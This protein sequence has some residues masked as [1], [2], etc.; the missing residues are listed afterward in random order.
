MAAPFLVKRRAGWYLRIRVPAALGIVLGSHLTRSL[1]TRDYDLARRR[2]VRAAARLQACW[3]EAWRDMD[4]RWRRAGALLTAEDLIR[5]D[6]AR[7]HAQLAAFSASFRARIDAELRA[8]AD[9]AAFAL[10]APADRQREREAGRQ[11]GRLEGMR[12]ALAALG[13]Q[14]RAGPAADVNRG[15]A[16]RKGSNRSGPA[17]PEI[18]E[19]ST[20]LRHLFRRS[21][22]PPGGPAQ[23]WVCWQKRTGRHPPSP[24]GGAS[25]PWARRHKR[26][27]P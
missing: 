16:V 3:E 2:A 23:T 9:D 17:K 1:R 14:R 12:E 26:A 19:N 22:S 8:V 13:D 11:Q 25:K 24:T 4:D 21:S 20:P 5:A 27:H 18:G 10:D 15:P 7:L 6:R